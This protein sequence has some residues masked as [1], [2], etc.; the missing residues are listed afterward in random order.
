MGFSVVVV[1]DVEQ[2]WLCYFSVSSHNF[3]S[4]RRA[5]CRLSALKILA[6]PIGIA[7]VFAL[8]DAKIHWR[9]F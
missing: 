1:A 4:V 3:S 2:L 5:F 9:A 8:T 6:I 7:P